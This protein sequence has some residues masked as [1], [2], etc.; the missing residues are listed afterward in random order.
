MKKINHKKTV[1]LVA[2]TLSLAV[3][4]SASAAPWTLITP[5]K[6]DLPIVSG[7]YGG[8]TMMEA[9]MI[10]YPPGGSAPN[11]RLYGICYY[12]AG[13]GAFYIG[14]DNA[15][16][17]SNTTVTNAA[18]QDCAV[19][20]NDLGTANDYVFA[21]A[22]MDLTAVL[23]KITFYNL[24]RS[25]TTF[26][27]TGSTTTKLPTYTTPYDY[28]IVRTDIIAKQSTLSLTGLPNTD[29]L[30]VCWFNGSNLFVERMSM[31]APAAA[32]AGTQITTVG[33]VSPYYD[34]AGIEKKVAGGAVHDF[35]L[36]T[37]LDNSNNLWYMEYD[38]TASS[39]ALGPTLIAT[40]SAAGGVG[41]IGWP[42]ISSPD[43]WSLHGV[44]GCAEYKIA[45][46]VEIP[47]S[48]HEVRTWS[49]A[50]AG[51]ASSQV[52]N[53]SGWT[54]PIYGAGQYEHYCPAIA[55]R[56][57]YTGTHYDV[58]HL[59]TVKNLSTGVFDE[60]V[61]V[62]PI[63]CNIANDLAK[64]PATSLWEYYPAN[65]TEAQYGPWIIAQAIT[66]SCNTYDTYT[67]NAWS[68]YNGTDYDI[69]RKTSNPVTTGYSYKGATSVNELTE[70]KLQVYPNPASDKLIINGSDSDDL[71]ANRFEIVDVTGRTVQS[72]EFRNEKENTIL[73]NSLIPGAYILNLY[74][75]DIRAEHMRFIKN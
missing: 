23:S 74:N 27:I 70:N 6:A 73:I 30:A 56:K 28:Y 22:Y 12:G 43:L 46:T 33:N 63:E 21:M 10:T 48:K 38:F 66:G 71:T 17:G 15:G 29:K 11:D 47:G 16:T 19:S 50:G 37:Y 9:A 34:V 62:E 40:G 3:A 75:K 61:M 41:T 52:I 49:S 36:V 59:T 51:W 2:L 58:S 53:L 24:T 25:G 7:I 1:T 54:P 68:T 44:P 31:S 42:R 55:T 14:D 67:F 5:I 26:T 32:I 39:V 20:N 60:R 65:K 45:A 4:N 35:A 57:G 13:G 64:N 72:G 18:R 69:Y 8:T